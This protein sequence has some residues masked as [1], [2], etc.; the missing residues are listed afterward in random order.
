MTQ[1][2][3]TVSLPTTAEDSPPLEMFSDL[4]VTSKARKNENPQKGC[5][6]CSNKEGG[7]QVK[8]SLKRRLLQVKV[9]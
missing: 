2:Q 7:E 1:K 6:I 5:G 9:R 8:N 4:Y 3:I